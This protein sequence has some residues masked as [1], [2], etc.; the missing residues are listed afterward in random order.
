MK[1]TRKKEYS[2]KRKRKLTEREI[3]ELKLQQHNETKAV[4]TLVKIVIDDRTSIHVTQSK[5]N[6]YGKQKCIELWKERQTV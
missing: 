1:A 4:Q 5:F 3:S 6:K 2:D